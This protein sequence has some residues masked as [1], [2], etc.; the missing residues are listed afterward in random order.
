MLKNHPCVPKDHY[1]FKLLPPSTPTS[2]EFILDP[3]YSCGLVIL[4]F[5]PGVFSRSWLTWA[6][7]SK[8]APKPVFFSLTPHGCGGRGSALVW[9]EFPHE[10]LSGSHPSHLSLSNHLLKLRG[11]LWADVILTGP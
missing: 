2:Q 8:L 9:S 7:P 1:D 3:E 10:L 5:L 11:K 6:S 4:W